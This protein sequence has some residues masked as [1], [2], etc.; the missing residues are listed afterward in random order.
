MTSLLRRAETTVGSVCLLLMFIIICVNIAMRYF[1]SSA[2]FWAE[3]VSNYLFVWAGFLSCAYI[4][5]RDEHIR[6]TI[7]TDKLPAWATRYVSAFNLV[8]LSIFFASMIW[9]SITLLSRLRTTPALRA[10]EAIPYSILA[11]TMVL[12]LLHCLV[13][14]AN[15]VSEIR[16]REGSGS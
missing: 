1:F 12:C 3:E 4:L 16:N 9:P 6:V 14:L 5:S 13:Q 8:L 15:L 10:P 7:L 2:I 11:I